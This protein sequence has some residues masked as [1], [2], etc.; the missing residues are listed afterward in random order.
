MHVILVV[1]NLQN[2]FPRT[3]S[4]L[5]NQSCSLTCG[6][7]RKTLEHDADYSSL[8]ESSVGTSKLVASTP[9]TD[10]LG[11]SS[12]A[13]PAMPLVSNALSLDSTGSMPASPVFIEQDSHT[14]D[15]HLEDDVLIR[16]ITVSDF[17]ST[18]SNMKD[19]NNVSSLPNTV[20]KK[21][22]EEWHHNRQKN[23]L[24]QQLHQQQ[25]NSFQ[26]QGAKSQM[27]FQGTD[28]TNINMDQYLHGSSKFSTEAQPVLQSS[29]FTPPLY[30]S[31]AAYMT[32]ANPFYPNLQPPGL[33]S[34]QYSFGGLA[35]NTAVLP[36]FVAGY[37][38]HGAMPLTFDGAALPSFNAQTSAVS[39]GE[40][41]TQ[42]VDIQ[43]LSK[44]Y[45]QLGYAPQPSF[46]DPLY[47]QYFQQ[48]FGEVYSVSGQFD[49]LVSRGGF[50]GGQVSAFDSQR[51]SDVASCSGDKKLQHQRS[52]GLVNVN[53]RRGSNGSPNYHGSPTNMGMLMQ[54][55]TSPLASPVL[56]RSPA[57]VT[58]LP[59]GR[60]EIRFPHGSGKNV[61][62]F[63]GWQGQRGYDD[64]K[65]HSFLEELKS[66]KGRRFEL[67]DIAGH[68][69]EFRQDLCIV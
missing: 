27:V 34:P 16:G 35:L 65:I 20:N 64:Q 10:D 9:G 67:S 51:E 29:G 37:P 45:G 61:G 15:D 50:I 49:S 2:D 24:Q 33:F 63:S 14:L 1:S 18:E 6:S 19:S 22:L 25:G 40:S 44:F 60:N 13:D 4:P 12:N 3:P 69:V 47:M 21:N 55:P 53:P 66:G 38:P 56:P 46:A 31:A 30:A 8:H 17:V 36:P 42:E 68:I 32:S 39:S 48:P 43:H 41:I 7:P 62:I 58:Y 59:G 26:V 11:P 54:F 57:G 52:G 28:H 5:Y 23:W